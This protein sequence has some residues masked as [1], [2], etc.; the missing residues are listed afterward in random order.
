MAQFL[1]LAYDGTDGEAPQRRLA[2]R[3]KHFEKLKTLIDQ[4]HVI[5]GAAILDDNGQMI[6]S[7]MLMDFADR[8]A[9]DL[10]LKEE[11]YVVGDVWRNIEIRPVRIA[12][13]ERA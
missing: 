12:H 13:P 3:P 1:V 5:A 6:G 11:P 8:A 10:W 4:G 2:I 7:T 9:L